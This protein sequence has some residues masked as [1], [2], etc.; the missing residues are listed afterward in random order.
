MSISL[1][2]RRMS[3]V[4]YRTDCLSAGSQQRFHVRSTQKTINLNTIYKSYEEKI[5]DCA[6]RSSVYNIGH[7]PRSTSPE[8]PFICDKLII[9][10][11]YS[12]FDLYY[13]KLV[14]EKPALTFKS[15]PYYTQ[16]MYIISVQSPELRLIDEMGVYPN[17]RGLRISGKYYSRSYSDFEREKVSRYNDEFA[18]S[19]SRVPDYVYR[20]T[21]VFKLSIAYTHYRDTYSYDLSNFILDYSQLLSR[22]YVTSSGD[23]TELRQV[24]E[25]NFK[26]GALVVPH[27]AFDC[28][29]FRSNAFEY[30]YYFGL[31]YPASADWYQ[32]F[33]IP[34]VS[35]DEYAAAKALL[36]TW[37]ASENNALQ[38]L[39]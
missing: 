35:E 5:A 16:G 31:T 27:D 9:D 12:G 18:H 38:Y 8:S 30:P 22:L 1:K 33:L 11:Y 17:S 4:T 20:S 24:L 14:F 29:L 23:Y 37:S 34:F 7:N 15:F 2:I 39:Q 6:T 26:H 36:H 19:S 10:G 25:D 28:L 21:D 3:S 32:I 13:D